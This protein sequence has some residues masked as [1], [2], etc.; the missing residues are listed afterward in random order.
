MGSSLF[1]T[2]MS[3]TG[4]SATSLFATGMFGLAVQ[5]GNVPAIM[6]P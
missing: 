6:L 3:A 2:G 5:S 4:M 1:A